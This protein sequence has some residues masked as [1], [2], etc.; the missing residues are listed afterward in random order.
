MLK[1]VLFLV[2]LPYKASAIQLNL[3]YPG[4]GGE[5]LEYLISLG[6]SG[7]IAWLYYAII[8]LSSIVAFGVIVGS[9][10]EYLTSAGNPARMKNAID[11][12]QNAIIGLL[13]VLISGLVVGTISPRLLFLDDP[14]SPMLGMGDAGPVEFPDWPEYPFP[15]DY[16]EPPLVIIPGNGP[17]PG[18]G[19]GAPP[20][21]VGCEDVD[22]NQV[23]PYGDPVQGGGRLTG[24]ANSFYG[25]RPFKSIYSDACNYTPTGKTG[26]FHRGVDMISI[27]GGGS[28]SFNNPICTRAKG[29]VHS[30]NIGTGCLYI[31]HDSGHET[32]YTHLN[33]INVSNGQRV[34]AGQQIGTMGWRGYVFPK[35]V[36]GTHLH[37][38][39]RNP[40]GKKN[41][42]NPCSYMSVPHCRTWHY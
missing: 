26:S 16:F 22:P 41:H 17:D 20:P 33:T 36:D 38:E 37:Y 2:F 15:D 18:P 13:L 39:V 8:V 25:C 42:K 7:F 14:T 3:N 5:S 40:S 9:G 24:G 19:N 23:V 6:L 27:K 34:E 30:T 1:F 31:K 21:G 11:R 4:F 32:Y 12:L 35:S 28:N 29:T 10:V